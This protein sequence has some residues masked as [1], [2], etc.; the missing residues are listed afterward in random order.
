MWILKKATD[1]ISELKEDLNREHRR[2]VELAR[3]REENEAALKVPVSSLQ[4]P[5]RLPGEAEGSSAEL[6]L[7]SEILSIARRFRETLLQPA[8]GQ[9]PRDDGVVDSGG[10]ELSGV[11]GAELRSPAAIEVRAALHHDPHLARCRFTLVPRYVTEE[12]FLQ[13]LFHHIDKARA[14]ALAQVRLGEVK[15]DGAFMEE[16]KRDLGLDL[17]DAGEKDAGERR[18]P[19]VEDDELERLQREIEMELKE[20]Y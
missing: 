8:P 11:A 9:A 13:R 4:P 1:K 5:W 6:A 17:A 18:E 10:R 15:D 12:V 14:R 16:L 2:S 19:A 3:I 20:E 7:R